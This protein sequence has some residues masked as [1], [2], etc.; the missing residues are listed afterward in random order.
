MHL[1]CKQNY[2]T[3]K[4]ES[5]EYHTTNENQSKQKIIC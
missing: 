2:K 3:F 1:K 5:N 4:I